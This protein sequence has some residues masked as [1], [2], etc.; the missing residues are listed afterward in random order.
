MA[1]AVYVP[2]GTWTQDGR[3]QSRSSQV[4]AASSLLPCSAL[5]GSR[6]STVRTNVPTTSP[7]ASSMRMAPRAASKHVLSR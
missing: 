6:R 4:K 5:T 3:V 2:A 1:T 7:D